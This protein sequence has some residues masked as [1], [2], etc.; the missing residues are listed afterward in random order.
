MEMSWAFTYCQYCHPSMHASR[1]SGLH[2]SLDSEGAGMLYHGSV[3]QVGLVV[4]A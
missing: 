2:D 3:C 4:A 1:L